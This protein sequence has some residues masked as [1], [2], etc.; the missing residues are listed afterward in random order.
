M[1]QKIAE[2]NIKIQGWIN[3]IS[4]VVF[5]VPII[6]IF[7]K[8]TGLSLLE[9]V[10]ISNIT[11]LCVWFFELPTSVFADTTGRKKSMLYSVICNALG[12]LMILLFPHFWGFIIAAVFASLYWSFWSGTGQAF[13]EENLRVLKNEKEFGKKIG[14]FM[15]YEQLAT[16]STPLIASAILKSFG[17]RG[18]AILAGLDVFFALVLVFLVLKLETTQIETQVSTL[19]ESFKY[20]INTAKTALKNVFHNPKIKTF[21]VYRSLS[22]HML[23]LGIILLPVLSEKGMLDWYSGIVTSIG[24]I[25][26]MFASKY[27]YKFAEKSSYNLAWILGTTVQGILL[28]LISIFLDSWIVVIVLYFLFSIFDGLW[29]PSWNHVLVEL[30]KGKAIA[31]TRSIIFAIF[32]LYITIGKQFLTFFEVETALLG[33]GV[34]IVLVN[35]ILGQKI[36]QLHKK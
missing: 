13:L 1:N 25:G 2:K 4:G 27:A 9:I 32:A 19:K 33:L 5:L 30:T 8:Y 6:T 15:F 14:Q 34:F 20:Q 24:I 23:F 21:L 3:F 12:A 18:Y 28:I 10:I 31:T 16:L 17:N 22:H 7:Y 29:Q 35:V 11:T 26:S 36:L